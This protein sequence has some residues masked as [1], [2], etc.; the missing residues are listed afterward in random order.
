VD[1]LG[2]DSQKALEKNCTLIRFDINVSLR[3]LFD[4]T[5]D[6]AI[7]KKALAWNKTETDARYRKK[8]A[9]AWRKR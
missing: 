1:G 6:E 3:N 8:Y 7:K 9:T 2:C 5:R 4:A